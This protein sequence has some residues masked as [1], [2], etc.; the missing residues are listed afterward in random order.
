[1]QGKKG[2]QRIYR[3]PQRGPTG[4][5]SLWP[6]PSVASHGLARRGARHKPDT[7]CRAVQRPSNPACTKKRRARTRGKQLATLEPRAHE[8]KTACLAAS[9]L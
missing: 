7:P 8:E 6:E 1:M 2:V 5:L 9:G 3:T 4:G